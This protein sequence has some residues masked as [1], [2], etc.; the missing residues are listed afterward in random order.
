MT[1]KT[2]LKAYYPNY[3]GDDLIAYVS[4]R[5]ALHCNDKHMQAD[6]MGLSSD[7]SVNEFKKRKRLFPDNGSGHAEKRRVYHDAIPPGLP[8]SLARRILKLQQ[9][10]SIAEYRFFHSLNKG[11]I[12]YLWPGASISLYEKLKSAGYFVVTE[13]INTLLQ[14]SKRILDAEYASLGIKTTH[15]LTSEAAE[16]EIRC[17]ELSDFIFSPSPGV[18]SSILEAGIPRSKILDSSYGL[19]NNEIYPQPQPRQVNKPVTAIFVG[20]ICIR[21]G[22]HLLLQ[23]W[24]KADTD[25][26]LNVVGRISPEAEELLSSALRR[27]PEIK[28]ID[29]VN[30]LEPIYREADFLILPSLEEGSPLVSYLALG[31]WLPLV[32]SPMGSGG[33]VEHMLDG[34]IVDPHNIDQLAGAIRTMATDDALRNRLSAAAG[35][36]APM[37]TWDQVAHRRRDLLI[38]RMASIEVMGIG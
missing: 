26:R 10:H 4:L 28:H 23:A 29:F 18:T 27:R 1:K 25:A 31:A 3:Y 37:Y 14:N 30:D 5:I 6:V 38:S 17:M 32:V 2:R 15:G 19:E 22:I 21:K 9:L 13:R 16:E 36:K 33:I 35:A 11:D 24:E 34:L 7:Q 12:I 20:T 8:W